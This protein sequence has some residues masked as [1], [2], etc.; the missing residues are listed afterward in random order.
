M[1]A[2]NRWVRATGSL[3]DKP[4]SIQ[5]REDWELARQ[6]ESYPL[7][8]QIAWNAGSVDDSTGFPGLAEQSKILTFGEHLQQHLEP[9][10][11]ALVTMVI[12][13]D[14]VCQWIIY[15]KDIELLKE[16]LD[17]IPTGEGLYPIEVVADED[18]LW[19]T[20]TQVYQAIRPEA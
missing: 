15:C 13:H 7:C 12:T 18:P 4:I 2:N 9:A 1:L 16:G 6:S 20:F 3:N 5:Y 8:V 10:E 17:R 19:Q 11:N 14:G